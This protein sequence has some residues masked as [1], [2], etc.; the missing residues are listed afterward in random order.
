MENKAEIQMEMYSSCGGSARI[1]S[2]SGDSFGPGTS[3][4]CRNKQRMGHPRKS[5]MSQP[6][7]LWSP[8]GKFSKAVT[9]ANP[10]SKSILE[11]HTVGTPR[12][13]GFNLIHK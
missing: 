12:V 10:V 3:L 4:A 7:C 11:V 8:N 6:F 13:R 1:N 5:A 9:I 2:I